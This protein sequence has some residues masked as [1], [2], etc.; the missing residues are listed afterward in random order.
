M[1]PLTIEIHGTGT[2][3]R[4]AELMAIAIAERM[5]VRYPDVRIA[6]PFFGF[7]DFVA[8]GRHGFLTT[9][10]LPGRLRGKLTSLALQH[11]SPKVRTMLGIINPGD[12]D[13]VIDASGFAF[14]DQ[15]GA[16]AARELLAK[17]SQP[18]RRGQRLILLPQAL[19]PFLNAEVATASR[20]LFSR[21]DFVCA[22]DTQSYMAS[23][24][25]GGARHLWQYP[26]FTISVRPEFSE[27]ARLP[28]KFTAI[29]PN[30]RM[31]DKTG[32]GENY[33]NFLRNVIVLLRDKNLNPI[34][35]LH[36][37]DEDHKVIRRVDPEGALSVLTHSDPRVLKGI[38]GRAEMVIGS[39]F[40]ALVSSL[41]QGV[42]CVGAGW[43]HKYQELFRDFG[44]EDFLLNDLDDLSRQASVVTQ[45]G[46]PNQR[47]PVVRRIISAGEQLKQKSQEMWLKVDESISACSDK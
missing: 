7:G 24:R 31:L 32:K 30:Y 11:G 40:H 38:L 8:R 10:E 45:L 44:V 13:V 14:S 6:V 39:R 21:A 36:D 5:R 20:D 28:S 9:W 16:A 1:K 35:L 12:V 37:A 34:F 23:E 33:L 42:P 18:H 43:S 29:V 19:G 27:E 17:M 15:M 22:R 3:N 25:L 4:G 46:D 41:S 26:D 2:H 47:A